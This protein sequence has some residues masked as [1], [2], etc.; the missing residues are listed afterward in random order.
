MRRV[1]LW[2][3]LTLGLISVSL[4]VD[5]N[6]FD[7][8]K[9]GG[10]RPM[11]TAL[12]VTWAKRIQQ[13]FNLKVWLSNQIAMGLEAWDPFTVPP[14]ACAN[15]GIGMEFPP[16]ACV[17]HAFAQGYFEAVHRSIEILVMAACVPAVSLRK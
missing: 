14:T 9:Y 11:K 12:G 4:A 3:C 10:R 6:T 16:G 5:K 2:G 8:I 1:I 13:G 17:E 15:P 7:F